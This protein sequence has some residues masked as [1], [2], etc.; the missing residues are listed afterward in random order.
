MIACRST[1]LDY[2]INLPQGAA[3]RLLQFLNAAIRLELPFSE[4]SFGSKAVSRDRH[5]NPGQRL[6]K[7]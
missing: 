3:A 2:I 1:N 5:Y 4:D 7:P 6:S